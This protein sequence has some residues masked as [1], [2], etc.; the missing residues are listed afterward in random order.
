M[1]CVL[2]SLDDRKVAAAKGAYHLV[3]SDANLYDAIWQERVNGTVFHTG[4]DEHDI[5]LVMDTTSKLQ[6][7]PV[8]QTRQSQVSHAHASPTPPSY[9]AN[10]LHYI[11]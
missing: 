10:V 2:V 1:C 11:E 8:P 7:P 3:E 4:G 5:P 6:Q 9:S